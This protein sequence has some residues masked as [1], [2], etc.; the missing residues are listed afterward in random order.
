MKRLAS[1][2]DQL[3]AEELVSSLTRAVIS[4]RDVLSMFWDDLDLAE[5]GKD[6]ENGNCS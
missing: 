2:T 1:L 4:S 5:A 6:D 3:I